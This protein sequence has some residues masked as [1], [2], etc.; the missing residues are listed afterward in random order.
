MVHGWGRPVER[1]SPASTR[2]N[3]LTLV[4]LRCLL[5]LPAAVAALACGAALSAATGCGPQP[6]PGRPPG[7]SARSPALAPRRGPAPAPT[8]LQLRPG[9]PVERAL[10]G[11]RVEAFEIDLVAGQYLYATF[12]QRGVDVAVDVR[13]AGGDPLFEVDRPY[14]AEGTER[15]HLVAET[16]GRYRLEARGLE[17]TP[18]GRYLVRVEALRAATAADR[19]RAAAE[20]AFY[21]A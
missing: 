21:E 8:V 18:A 11:G 1:R 6:A 12:E 9:P 3:A 15:V 20:R 7:R 13:G 19:R 17:G 16:S 2:R 10:A 5:R 4:R 14:D